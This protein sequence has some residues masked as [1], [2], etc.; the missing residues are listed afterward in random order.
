M[1]TF[2][3]LVESKVRFPKLIKYKGYHSVALPKTGHN[4]LRSSDHPKGRNVEL[5]L[6]VGPSSV[7]KAAKYKSDRKRSSKNHK[8]QSPSRNVESNQESVDRKRREKNQRHAIRRKN[9]N[10][11]LG[12][13]F[14]VWRDLIVLLNFNCLPM[15]R[16]T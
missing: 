15:L 7:D 14:H 2:F 1:F 10:L 13:F 16:P 4:F 9:R 11:S 6:N 8:P 3:R 5:D 12:Q